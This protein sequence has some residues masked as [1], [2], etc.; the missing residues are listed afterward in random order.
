MHASCGHRLCRWKIKL[1]NRVIRTVTRLNRIETLRKRLLQLQPKPYEPPPI[2]DTSLVPPADAE[3]SPVTDADSFA[4]G[5][6]CVCSVCLLLAGLASGFIALLMLTKVHGG[7]L[8][9]T[10][11]VPIVFPVLLCVPVY[12][13]GL[14]GYRICHAR[15][16]PFAKLVVG[17]LLAF[18]FVPACLFACLLLIS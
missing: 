8:S 5:V 1:R 7:S 10:D 14:W 15:L 18:P 4:K 6:V 3:S 2:H 16:S 9:S 11:L 13:F 12:F 17:C